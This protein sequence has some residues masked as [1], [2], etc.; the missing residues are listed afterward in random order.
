MHGSPLPS[1]PH[2]ASAVFLGV[3]GGT[4]SGKSTVVQRI[5]EALGPHPVTRIQ[6]DSYYHD[7]G[8]LPSEERNGVN[9]DHPDALDTGLL[10]QHLDALRQG[11]SVEVPDY[12]FTTH[13]RSARTRVAH[14]TT[15]IIVDG[16]LVLADAELRR[17]LDIKIYVD[18]DADIRLVRRIR[19]DLADR[20]R[21]LN[22]VIRQYV[23]SV[24]PMHLEFVEPSKR[25]ADVIVPVGGE[26]RVAIDMVVAKLRAEL[27]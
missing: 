1:R 19:R 20:G 7:F 3:A 18:T 6:H 10:I 14:P 16:I 5:V 12:D 11:Q 22:S 24:R 8:H 4:G 15:V 25:Y 13:T 9:F 2:M 21:T 23:D 17:R 26:N 27:T